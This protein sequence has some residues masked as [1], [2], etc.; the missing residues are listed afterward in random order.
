[1]I[2]SNQNE[3]HNDEGLVTCNDSEKMNPI[4]HRIDYGSKIVCSNNHYTTIIIFEFTPTKDSKS[5]NVYKCHKQVFIAM[6]I[7]DNSAKI[8]T[9]EG[10]NPITLVISPKDKSMKSSSRQQTKHSIR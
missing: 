8:T 9:N 5:L 1:M 6:K 2:S 10:K 3:N 7:F 4:L